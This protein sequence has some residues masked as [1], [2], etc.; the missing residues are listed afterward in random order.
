MAQD[1]SGL[2]VDALPEPEPDMLPPLALDA[3]SGDSLGDM[4]DALDAV[5]V[6]VGGT[7]LSLAGEPASLSVDVT[8]DPLLA[9]KGELLVGMC[10]SSGYP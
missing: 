9:P 5:L 7:G 4:V 1:A 6:L 3:A 2:S 8:D 10:L